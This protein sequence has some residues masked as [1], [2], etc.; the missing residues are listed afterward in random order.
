M[1][2]VR[3]ARIDSIADLVPG[4]EQDWLLIPAA[5]L[6]SG[7]NLVAMYVFCREL[8]PEVRQPA[9][10]HFPVDVEKDP[11]AQALARKSWEARRAKG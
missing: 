9:L 3:A 2:M 7:L 5:G 1:S 10:V 11:A 8:K 6:L 4:A